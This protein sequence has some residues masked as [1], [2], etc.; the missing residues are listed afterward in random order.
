MSTSTI[1]EKAPGP[2]RAIARKPRIVQQ[3]PSFG[4]TARLLRRLLLDAQAG[5]ANTGPSQAEGSA[6]WHAA[7]LASAEPSAIENRKQI[8][9]RLERTE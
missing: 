8:Y 4:Y 2:T 7:H 3:D 9:A 5:R 6:I 1:Q